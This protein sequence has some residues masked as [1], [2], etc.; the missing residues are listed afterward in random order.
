VES[1]VEDRTC[2]AGQEAKFFERYWGF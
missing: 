1:C 2:R